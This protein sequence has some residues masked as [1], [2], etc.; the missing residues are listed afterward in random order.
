LS[1]ITHVVPLVGSNKPSIVSRTVVLPA[2]FGPNI[3]KTPKSTA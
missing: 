1:P 3:P 2:P